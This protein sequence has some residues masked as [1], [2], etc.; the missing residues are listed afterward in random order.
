VIQREK[1]ISFFSYTRKI[2]RFLAKNFE[3]LLEF[4]ALFQVNKILKFDVFLGCFLPIFYQQ[5]KKQSVS[6]QSTVGSPLTGD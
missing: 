6:R 5:I 3:N 2:I 4:S 1:K